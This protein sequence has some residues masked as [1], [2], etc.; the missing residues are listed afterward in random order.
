MHR[1]CDETYGLT[2]PEN[3]YTGKVTE[4]V[5]ILDAQQAMKPSP[6]GSCDPA[7]LIANPLGDTKSS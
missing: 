3:R 1:Q 4:Q 6:G 2:R 7:R 5:R